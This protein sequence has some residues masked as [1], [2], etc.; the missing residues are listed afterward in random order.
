MRLYLHGI[1]IFALSLTLFVCESLASVNRGAVIC[2][3]DLLSISLQE[4]PLLEVLDEIAFAANVEIYLAK[5]PNPGPVSVE[6]SREHVREI[7]RRLLKGENYA[8]VYNPSPI[9]SGG[10][11]LIEE[12]IRGSNGRGGRLASLPRGRP[13]SGAVVSGNQTGQGVRSS[14]RGRNRVEQDRE[15]TGG[16]VGPS[17]VRSASGGRRPVSVPA[18]G[19][20][21]S[22]G[23]SDDGGDTADF[24][25]GGGAVSEDLVSRATGAV[26]SS[27]GQLGGEEDSWQGETPVEGQDPETEYPAGEAGRWDYDDGDYYVPGPINDT[28]RRAYLEGQIAMLEDRVY[29]GVSAMQ[30]EAWSRRRDPRYRRTDEQRLEYYRNELDAWMQGY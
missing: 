1:I 18:T 15:N 21:F 27:Q 17:A 30:D 19:G 13:V 26:A 25:D 8:V 5:V 11:L 12:K 4:R 10:V 9:L 20:G 2:E 16:M 3:D 6:C 14:S 22:G 7:L 23:G 24:N 28:S 29:N